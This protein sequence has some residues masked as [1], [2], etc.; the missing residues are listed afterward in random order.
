[1]FAGR[2][3]QMHLVI[4]HHHFAVPVKDS[5]CIINLLIPAICHGTGNYIDTIFFR[6]S[7]K[8]F[9]VC[10]DLHPMPSFRFS[11]GKKSGV[12]RLRKCNHIRFQLCSHP[13]Q[14][15]CLLKIRLRLPQLHIHLESSQLSYLTS[16]FCDIWYSV[17]GIPVIRIITPLSFM[18]NLLFSQNRCPFWMIF[19]FYLAFRSIA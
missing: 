1:M 10:S 4:F 12:P 15:F 13:D 9:L 3:E 18:V 2:A 19:Q 11:L 16:N 17:F 14:L 8:Q 5:G 6:Q 7:G